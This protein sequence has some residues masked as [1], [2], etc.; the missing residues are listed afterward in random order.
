MNLLEVFNS[1]VGKCAYRDEKKKI[2]KKKSK[3]YS[4]M[5]L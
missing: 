2:S 5:N 4:L 3:S 1:L